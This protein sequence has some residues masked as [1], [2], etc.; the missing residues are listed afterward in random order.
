MRCDHVANNTAV[1][2]DMGDHSLNCDASVNYGKILQFAVVT[3][4]SREFGLLCGNATD[5]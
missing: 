3:A 1:V 4:H 5:R 2:P